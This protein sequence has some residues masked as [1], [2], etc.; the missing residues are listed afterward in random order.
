MAPIIADGYQITLSGT[1]G[2]RPWANVFAFQLAGGAPPT[3]EEAA[4]AV[5]EAWGT[6][7]FTNTTTTTELL[8]VSWLDLSSLTGDSGS[9]DLAPSYEGEDDSPAASP[10]VAVLVRWQAAG[11]RS[12]RGG[13]TFIPGMAEAGID[14]GGVVDLAVRNSLEGELESYMTAVQAA[15]LIPSILSRTGPSAGQMRTIIGQSIDFRA[16]TQRRRQRS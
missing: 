16:A 15:D 14:A 9:K 10:Q 11:G 5:A 4:D 6:T 12:V 7:V 8:R 3:A 13:R 2:G 1:T